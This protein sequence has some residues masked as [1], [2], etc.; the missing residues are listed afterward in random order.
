MATPTLSKNNQPT[1]LAINI[2]KDLKKDFLITC[3]NNDEKMT[4]VL[5]KL[6]HKYVNN[7]IKV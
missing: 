4:Q 5:H 1:R 3:A 6:I 7:E 2:D